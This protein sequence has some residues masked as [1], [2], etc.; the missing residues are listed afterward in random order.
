MTKVVVLLFPDDRAMAA[1]L[2][3]IASAA[4]IAAEPTVVLIGWQPEE[5]AAAQAHGA[6]EVVLVHHASLVRPVQADQLV[7]LCADLIAREPSWNDGPTL[8]IL[9][10]GP[11]GEE[12]AARLAAR[13]GAAA[14][15]LCTRIE[16]ADGVTHG[17]RN[18]LGGRAELTLAGI[19]ALA[20]ASCHPSKAETR[21]PIPGPVRR[22]DIEVALPEPVEVRQLAPSGAAAKLDGA[23]IVVS[24][25]RGIG[26]LEGFAVLHDLAVALGGG[27]GGSLPTID[28][29]WLPVARQIGQSGH[30]VAPDLYLAVAISGTPQHLAGIAR[31]SRII[32]INNDPEAPIFAQASVAVI[33]DWKDLL[34][35]LLQRISAGSPAK[36][37][38]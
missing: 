1:Q 10:S 7:T 2:G 14:L 5:A 16:I 32:A 35:R 28:A 20:F 22:L 9:P 18:G 29:G 21:N 33:A 15:G 38:G 25:G 12:V 26:G 13:F 27:L 36:T 34:P 30:F 8:F 3:T 17:R 19:G 31:R 23:R 37:N 24:G 11:L 4:R 6:A